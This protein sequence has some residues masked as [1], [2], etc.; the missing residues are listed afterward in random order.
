MLKSRV[1]IS[2]CQFS[3]NS[4]GALEIHDASLRRPHHV[5]TWSI[6]RFSQILDLN[7]HGQILT[8]SLYIILTAL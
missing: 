7:H 6:L 8:M 2:E 5:V 4:M 1:L 3:K